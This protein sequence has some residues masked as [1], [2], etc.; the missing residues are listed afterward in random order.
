M[1]KQ[2]SILS[3]MTLLSACSLFSGEKQDPIPGEFAG[4]DYQLSDKNAKIWVAKSN[5]TEQCIYPTLTRIQLDH[6]AKEDKFIYMQ[7]VFFY[8]LEDI[9]GEQNLEIIKADQKSMDYVTYQRKKFGHIKSGEALDD[10]QCEILRK[11]ARD[12]LAV[13][14]GEYRSAMTEEKKA[15]DSKPSGSLDKSKFSFD[16]LKWGVSLI[17]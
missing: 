8:P 9:I 7:Y 2:F 10:T 3:I 6:F 17:L 16:I 14:K 4:A 5:Q 15:D 1:L 11:K 12:D 13:T